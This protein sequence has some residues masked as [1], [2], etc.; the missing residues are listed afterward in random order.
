MNN[1]PIPL[2]PA[3]PE[4]AERRS[5]LIPAVYVAIGVIVLLALSALFI[6]LLVYL[7]NN[8][9]DTILVV[10]DIFIIALGLMSC[11]SGIVLIL[12]LISIIRLINMLEFELKPI[13]LK[14]NDTLGT[15]RGTTVFMSENVVRPMATASSY[16]AG[17]RRGFLTLFGDPRRNLGK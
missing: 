3:M 14:T 9:A 12:L 4:S 7:A 13:L 5:F 11:L 15:I 8:Y 16:V 2:S 10:R 1:A 17:I 6:V